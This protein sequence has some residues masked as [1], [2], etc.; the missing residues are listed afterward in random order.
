M[1]EYYLSVDIGTSAY[2]RKSL[3]GEI[4]S[5]RDISVSQQYRTQGRIAVLE[6]ESIV[7]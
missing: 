7:F 1:G 4:S 5:G 6:S 3:G 2:T